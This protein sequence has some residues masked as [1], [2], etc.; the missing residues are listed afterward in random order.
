MR[1]LS[2]HDHPLAEILRQVTPASCPERFNFHC[3]TDCSDGSLKP[4]EVADQAIELGLEH[5]AVTD[6]HSLKAYRPISERF[7]QLRARGVSAPVIWRGVEISCVLK[8]CLVHVLALGFRENHSSL[9][10]Y[11]RGCAL[12]GHAL[13]G[14]AVVSAIHNSGGL[15]ILAHPARY[16][17]SFSLLIQAAAEIGFDGA[18]AWYDYEMQPRWHPTPLVCESIDADLRS[19]GLLASCGTDTHGYALCG[20]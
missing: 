7:E 6:H 17:L 18:E 11:L 16:R 19:R 20:R 5:L 1:K 3:H 14:E 2:R 12:V 8:G 10:P 15:A 13:R 9:D 4:L